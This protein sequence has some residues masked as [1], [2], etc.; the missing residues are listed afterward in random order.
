MLNTLRRVLAPPTFPDDENKTR[1]AYYINAVALIS[2]LAV[3]LLFLARVLLLKI[4]STDTSNFILL[5]II[6]A[7]GIGWAIMRSGAVMLAG[8]ITISMI[9]IGST[10]LAFT[11][12]GLRGSGFISYFVVILL[13]GLLVGARAAVGVAILSVFSAFGLSYIESIGRLIDPVDPPLDIAVESSFLFLLSAFIIWLII[14]SLRNALQA[15]ITNASQLEITNKELSE[16]RTALEVRIHERT[17]TL[18][19]RASQLQTV[20]TLARTIA[21]V[22]DLNVLLPN[23]ARLVSEQFGFYHTGIFLLDDSRSNAILKAASSEGGQRMLVREHQL[24]LDSE[25]IVGYVASHGEPRIALDVG[26]DAVYFNNPDLSETRSEIALPLRVSGKVI[27]AL[28]V[29]STQNNAFSEDDIEVLSTLADQV[30]IAIENARLFGDAQ[31]ALA[32][33]R[34][35]FEKYVQQE[36]SNFVQQ[37]RHTGFTFDGKQVTVLDTSKREQ[38]RAVMQTGSLVL[39]KGKASSTVSVPIKLRGQIIGVLDV[40]SKRGP[41][42][43]TR[44]EIMLLEAAAE[45][46]ALALENSRLL[47]GAQRRAARERTIGEISSK[48]GSASD[49]NSILRATVEEMGRRIGAAEVI[50]ELESPADRDNGEN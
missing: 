12:S 17:T 46:A 28:D 36:W 6:I 47:E 1:S 24:P 34:S 32:E 15:T 21:S 26:T 23:I 20:S 29:Q 41:R 18:E 14:T 39:E 30:A 16:L 2:A 9:W 11:G 50:F 49:F 10:L 43:W 31:K 40:R 8:Y 7:L 4:G 38:P 33:S 13:A 5:G 35:T 19:K 37:V 42:D 3:F 27:G 22:Q 48:I 45:R 44:E 25:S